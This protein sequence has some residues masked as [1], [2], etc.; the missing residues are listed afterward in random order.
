LASLLYGTGRRKTSIAKVWVKPGTGKMQIND[1]EAKEFFDRDCHI[2][3]FSAPMEAVQ[4]TGKYDIN[5]KVLGG[6]KTGQAGAL[7]MAIARALSKTDENV[8]TILSRG[9][10]LMRDNRMVERKKYGKAKAR[11]SFQFSKR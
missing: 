10:F 1:L 8:H 6:G 11:R 2:M 9:G 7:R 5:A 3:H 4:A